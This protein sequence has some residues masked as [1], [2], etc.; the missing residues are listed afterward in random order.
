MVTHTV[1]N[2]TD[3]YFGP[4]PTKEE[5][6]LG[7]NSKIVVVLMAMINSELHST[8]DPFE[9]QRHITAFITQR[10]PQHERNE[11][12][13][14]LNLFQKK[15]SE[16]FVIWGKRYVLEFM[17]YEFLNYREG[18]SVESTPEEEVKIFKAYLLVCEEV[19][20]KDRQELAKTMDDLQENPDMFFE[21]LVWPFVLKQ[22][23]TNN[24]VNP[25]FQFIKLL[26][27]IK[28][29][30]TNRELLASWKEFISING[31]TN[32]REYLGSVFFLIKTTQRNS[33]NDPLFKVFSWINAKELPKHLLNLSFYVNDFKN[34]EE[35][36]VDFK[37]L[38][39]KP[40][41]ESNQNEFV[42]LDLDYLNNKIY[43]GPLFDMYYQTNMASKTKFKKF[44]DFKNYIGTNVSEN[45]VFKGIVKKLFNK[46][47]IQLHFDD[48][49]KDN[50]PDCYIRSGNK[51]F[52]IE[53]K[54]YLFPGKIVD[55]YSFEK[56]K[57]HLDLK[58]IMNERGSNKGISQIVE[59]LKIIRTTKFDFDK[60]SHSNITIYPIIIHTN[61]TY[62]MPGVNYYLNQKL[63]SKLDD[64]LPNFVYNV[65]KL[66]L[67]DLESL[68]E[69][70][71][72]KKINLKVFES[73]LDRYE[74]ILTDRS[75]RFI[76][77]PNQTNFVRARSSFDEI[78]KT[79]INKENELQAENNRIRL[80]LDV[81]G[82][83]E[84]LLNSF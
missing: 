44:P 27:L 33:L 66:V 75:K 15:I 14:G 50:H 78:Y 72:L 18:E 56:I 45:I 60:F 51:I 23:S 20:E 32:L 29:S 40:L 77:N 63:Q 8:A 26:G 43:N 2:Y 80:L 7:I 42:I 37:G 28:Y 10:F 16:P 71:N 69:F 41:F 48:E 74:Q 47:H 13:N 46:V 25:V 58:F 84:E 31:F 34:N 79:I 35:K 39:E 52:L 9:T 24:Q 38:R 68:F 6:L 83:D 49:K 64:E 30:I 82:A 12:N 81:V 70:L 55:E 19:N 67:I 73:F 59:Q 17:K 22:F 3:I 65:K 11:L 5:L 62:Q 54:D 76:S 21:K 36:R 53:F 61:F 4:K 57:E 1:I